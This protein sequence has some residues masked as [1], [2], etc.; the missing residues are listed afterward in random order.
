MTLLHDYFNAVRKFT[1]NARMFLLSTFLSSLCVGISNVIFNL[2]ILKLGY[3]EKFLGLIIAAMMIATGIFAFPAAQVCDRLGSKKSL[4]IS[5]ILTSI[6]LYLLYTVTSQELLL[7]LS[8]M[9]GMFATIP[10][11]ISS[12]FLVENSN[13]NDRI[14]LFSVNFALFMV[15]TVLGTAFG[16][17]LP[18]IWET[19][20]GIDSAGV[21]SYRYT[22]FVSLI[23]ATAS[24]LPLVVIQE[25]K[26]SCMAT[27]DIKMVIKKLAASGKV[28]KL[29]LISCMIGLGAGLIVP[30]FNVYFNKI[31][32]ASPG[33]I[34]M[35]FSIAQASMVIGAIAVPFMV[36]RIGRVKTISLT[37]IISI[38]FLVIMAIS[39]NLYFVG[40]AYVLRMLF[41]NMSMPVSNSFSMEIVKEDEMAS[42]S[43]LTSMG[44]YIS[45][46]IS[47]FIAGIMMS[48]GSYVLPY[49]TA[50]LLYSGAA[51]LYF[52]FFK[53]Y[54]ERY[55]EPV[56]VSLDVTA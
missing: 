52:K 1:P 14:Y 49:F 33:Q 11:V 8:I 39:T 53:K 13:A 28:K 55:S 46:A 3:N 4:V 56:K 26:K 40:T 18:Q 38:P 10:T 21:D 27:P 29:V 16:G 6:T 19:I 35:I 50:C 45:I 37:Y 30:F 15:A 20:F 23:L 51:I 34:G 2:Y 36:S 44:S 7:F 12:P 24:V 25:K 47:T 31:L 42:V 22:L 41:M 32:A 54:E 43:S 17:Y 9:S 5:G 48:Y